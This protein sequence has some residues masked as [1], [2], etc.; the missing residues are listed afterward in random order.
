MSTYASFQG[1]VFLGKRDERR[2]LAELKAMYPD[3][4]GSRNGARRTR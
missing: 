4:V 3:A 1:R 2:L